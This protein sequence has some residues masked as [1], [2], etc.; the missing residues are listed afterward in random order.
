MS[1]IGIIIQ[2]EYSSR[3]KKK[4]FILLTFLMPVLFI[5][6]IFGTIFLSTIKDS[7]IKNI[8][9]YDDTGKYFSVLQDT[10]QYHFIEG[11]N[12]SIDSVNH[13]SDNIYATLVISNDLYENSSAIAL[14]SGTQVSGDLKKI[15]TGQ[16]EEFLREEKLNSY[17][18]PNL[19]K[20]IEKSKVTL[21]LQTITKDQEGN[22]KITSAE[23][24][25]AVGMIFTFIIYMFIFIYGAM[26]MQGVLEE[27]NNRIVEVMVSSVKPFDLMMGKIIG[28]GLVGLTQF[29]LW[30]VLIVILNLVGS[31][32]FVLPEITNTENLNQITIATAANETSQINEFLNLLS[33]INFVELIVCFVIF[34]IGGYMIYASLFAAIGSM[35]NSQEDTQQFIMP[36]TVLIL[37]A[38]YAGFYSTQNPDGP[39]AFWTSIIPLFSP[40]VM[41]TRIPFDVPFWEILLSVI[42]LYIT[43]Y[44]LVSL[45]ARIYRVGIL[46]YGKKPTIKEIWKWLST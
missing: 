27:K 9:V 42:L 28:I 31:A 40:I 16:L 7:G 6:L 35:V 36:I 41:M 23:I 11:K 38:F 5:A 14:Y 18:I 21:N 2:R 12:G 22:E 17:N 8:V 30:M 33:S 32:A 39:L 26:V 43:V 46:M 37:F 44:L 15:I 24:S 1:K 34:F 25:T 45:S 29:F 10:E 3:V 20:I 19:K 4:S 13:T